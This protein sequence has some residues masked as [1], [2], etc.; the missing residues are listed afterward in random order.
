MKVAFSSG[1]GP[2]WDLAMIAGTVKRLG[3]DGVE[4]R[5]V[6]G[7][8]YLPQ[9]P[10]LARDP[11]GVA[12]QFQDAGSQIICLA[13]S[14]S[15]G[16]PG[17]TLELREQVRAYIELATKLHCPM[18]RLITGE[19]SV[20]SNR[21]ATLQRQVDGL[22]DLVLEASRR[23]VMLLLE[24]QGTLS[25]SRDIWFVMDALAHPALRASWN[26]VAGY[27]A[28][29]RPTLAVP[30]LG[31][32]TQMVRLGDLQQPA[33]STATGCVLGAGELE[34][35]RLLELLVGVGYDGWLLVDWPDSQLHAQPDPEPYLQQSLKFIREQLAIKR[36]PLTAYKGDKNAP[37]YQP[38]STAGS[39]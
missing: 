22:R 35:A 20:W 36:E 29:E 28:G 31:I 38:R 23:G 18:I 4:L 24:N 26:H 15:L 10:L 5:A 7:E 19:V 11:Q 13:S 12:K 17:E 14:I 3:F 32:R 1:C 37:R 21:L 39:A 27:H 30:R 16:Q 34:L 9:H 6:Q 8:L 25:S 2:T 33:G